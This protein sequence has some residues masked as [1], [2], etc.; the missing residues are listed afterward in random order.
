M[1]LELVQSFGGEIRAPRFAINLAE[2]Q[3]GHDAIR[4]RRG[5]QLTTLFQ[6]LNRHVELPQ[7]KQGSTLYFEQVLLEKRILVLRP[8]CVSLYQLEQRSVVFNRLQNA[9]RFDHSTRQ[10]QFRK[11]RFRC[12]NDRRYI[13]SRYAMLKYVKIV[14]LE[15]ETI[16]IF[17]DA[18]TLLHLALLSINTGEVYIRRNHGGQAECAMLGVGAELGEELD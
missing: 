16:D 14:L 11:R 8:V 15:P 6:C 18:Q 17:E 4:V 5:H 2:E 9:R 7:M 13:S 10:Q 3:M 1:I 12:R